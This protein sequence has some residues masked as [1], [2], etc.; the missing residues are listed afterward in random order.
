MEKEKNERVHVTCCLV[1]N[2]FIDL[3]RTEAGLRCGVLLIGNRLGPLALLRLYTEMRW[4]IVLVIYATALYGCEKL[5]EKKK[6]MSVLAPLDLQC[7][8]FIFTVHVF[9]TGVK[10]G[11]RLMSLYVLH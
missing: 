6:C 8:L 3:C 11:R 2:K 4:L 10:I 9:S 5:Y 1:L 7:T